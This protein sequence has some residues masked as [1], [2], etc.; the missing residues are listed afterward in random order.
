MILFWNLVCLINLTINSGCMATI[1][2]SLVMVRVKVT[3]KEVHIALLKL[4]LY[5]SYPVGGV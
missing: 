5:I 3:Q 4:T 2:I 1:F